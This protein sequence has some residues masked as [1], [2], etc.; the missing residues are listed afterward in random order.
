[1]NS[2]IFQ[3]NSNVDFSTSFCVALLNIYKIKLMIYLVHV[4]WWLRYYWYSYIKSSFLKCWKFLHKIKHKLPCNLIFVTIFLLNLNHSCSS[5]FYQKKI[6]AALPCLFTIFMSRTH[7][8]SLTNTSQLSLEKY[9]KV[10]VEPTINFNW[11]ALNIGW[12]FEWAGRS[13]LY[14]VSPHLLMIL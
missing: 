12:T 7:S 10:R 3:M 14:A 4:E 9:V 8:G 2:R 13:N 1:M 5:L 6:T 11:E